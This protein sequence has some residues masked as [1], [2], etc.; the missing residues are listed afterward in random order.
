MDKAMRP[1][2]M[3]SGHEQEAGVGAS[4]HQSGVRHGCK[5]RLAKNLELP[6]NNSYQHGA[7]KLRFEFLAGPILHTALVELARSS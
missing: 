4:G 1:T 6:H 2:Q 5:S 7:G 3:S